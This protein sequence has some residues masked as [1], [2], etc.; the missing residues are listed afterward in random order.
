MDPD[1][2]HGISHRARAF[3]LL[4]RHCLPPTGA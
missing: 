1:L 3:A 2:K 4:A